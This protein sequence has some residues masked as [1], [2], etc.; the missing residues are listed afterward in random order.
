MLPRCL[1]YAMLIL[2]PSLVLAEDGGPEPVRILPGEQK[3][4]QWLT[5]LKNGDLAFSPDKD[6]VIDT[7]GGRYVFTMS[8]HYQQI[9]NAQTKSFISVCSSSSLTVTAKGKRW[10][11]HAF[12]G[13]GV[14]PRVSIRKGR[15]FAFLSGSSLFGKSSLFLMPNGETQSADGVPGA[16]AVAASDSTLYAAHTAGWRDRL[17][18]YALSPELEII[19]V[20]RLGKHASAVHLVVDDTGRPHVTYYDTARR[21]LVYGRLEGDAFQLYKLDAPDSGFEHAMDVDDADVVI[22]AYFIR[23]P[24]NKGLALY[25]I[26]I[27]AMNAKNSIRRRIF[28]RRKDENVGWAPVVS[29]NGSFVA[30]GVYNRTEDATEVYKIQK[31]EILR[32]NEHRPEWLLPWMAEPKNLDLYFSLGISYAQWSTKVSTDFSGSSISSGRYR[33]D[34]FLLQEVGIGGEIGGTSFALDYMANALDR[35]TEGPPGADETYRFFSGMIG[36]NEL[37]GHDKT[38][39]AHTRTGKL[40]GQYD[41]DGAVTNFTTRYFDFDIDVFNKRGYFFWGVGYRKFSTPQP[42]VVTQNGI[43]L[44][45]YVTNADFRTYSVLVGVSNL[46]YLRRYETSFNNFYIDAR[47]YIGIGDVTLDQ[48]PSVP[49]LQ[50]RPLALRVAFDAG[51]LI[52]R[53]PPTLG[54]LAWFASLGVSVDYTYMNNEELDSDDNDATKATVNL[55]RQDLLAGVFLKAGL[56]F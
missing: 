47:G 5:M 23:N 28:L 46:N 50:T 48:K 1:I 8:Y 19:K 15:I 27:D 54:G 49:I 22:A 20:H 29:T 35:K 32:E 52:L 33:I 42:V 13:C 45:Q 21:I 31:E 9:Y 53:R 12:S 7:D 4:R 3:G 10:A 24:Y 2:L 55:D 37:I 38:L 11:H 39:E 43:V 18:I 14:K 30:L 17:D 44:E 6:T 36:I 56:A 40:E 41:S 26:P 16:V 34:P 25:R 51:Y